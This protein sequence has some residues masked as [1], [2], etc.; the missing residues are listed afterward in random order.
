VTTDPGRARVPTLLGGHAK[1]IAMGV[2][3]AVL[4]FAYFFADRKTAAPTTPVVTRPPAVDLQPFALDR[5]LLKQINDGSKADRA[6]L[7]S[8]AWSHLMRKSYNIGPAVADALRVSEQPTD[9]A[10]LRANPGQHRGEFV[11]LKGR[12]VEFHAEDMEHPVPRAIAYKGRLVTGEGD[13]VLFYVS[14]PYVDGSQAAAAPTSV[15]PE[16]KAPWVRIEGFFMKIR[17]EYILPNAAKD[18]IGAPLI[19]GPRLEKAY[20]DWNAVEAL[21]VSVLGR[22]KNAV[23]DQSKKRWIDAE[24]MFTMLAD[25]ED[26]PLW[27]MASFA[28]HEYERKKGTDLRHRIIFEV[29]DQYTKFKLGEFPQGE[30]VRLRGTFIAA[31]IFRARTNPVGI[32]FWSEVWI[33]IPRMGAKLIPIWIPRD[34]G[35]WT[36]G[37]GVD[38]DAFFFKNYGYSVVDG[39]D[40]HTPLFVA[41]DLDP[42]NLVTNPAA[43]WVGGG[44]AALL[45]FVA[46]IF[47]RM[48]KRAR[49]DSEDYKARLVE[50]RRQRRGSHEQGTLR[51][52]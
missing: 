52:S 48:N 50:R 35:D 47:F 15:I 28:V 10:A 4:L 43:K 49:L 1:I 26:V 30:A 23:W 7:E 39:A 33:R 40:R 16:A 9:I 18:I 42:F 31:R 5:E 24:D 2:V 8:A 6:F 34:I 38:V 17:D 21:D 29:E 45:M 51:T 27:H 13:S 25:S 22:V 44:F 41:G 14:K 37:A 46:W 36:R 20:P 12:L 3:L 19:I 11:R 32:R